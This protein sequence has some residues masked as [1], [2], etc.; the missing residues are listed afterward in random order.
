[1]EGEGSTTAQE[2][3]N[4]PWDQTQLSELELT[5]E[6]WTAAGSFQRFLT[7]Q[8]LAWKLA[9]IRRRS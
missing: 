9:Q 7:P 5:R 3:K 8:K 2:L 4:E 6:F 1:M